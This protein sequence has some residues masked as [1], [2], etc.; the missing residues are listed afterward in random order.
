M[1]TVRRELW[2]PVQES[3]E[4]LAKMP[5]PS[6]QDANN[7]L[8][9]IGDTMPALGLAY[10][11]TGDR[12][13]IEAADRW[14]RALVAVPSWNGSANLGRSSWV[15]G[16]ALLYDWL[17][18]VLPKETRDQVRTRL[19][20]E[21]EILLQRAAYWRLLSNHCLIETSALGFIGLALAGEVP[22]SDAFLQKARERTGQIIEHAPLDGSWGE[23]IQY[24]QYGLGY[25]LRY[26]E[27]SRT[28]GDRDYYPSYEWL[29]KTGFFAIH[30]SLPGRPDWSVNFS[31]SGSQDYVGSFL[32]YLPASIYGNGYYQDFGNR[33]RSVAAYKFS[34]MDFLAYD[35]HVQPLDIRTLPTFKHFDDNGF[36]IMRSGWE[37]ASTLIGF[38]A[39]PAPGHRN[40]ADPHRLEWRGFGP[41]HGH[42]DINSFCLFAFGKWLALDPGYVHEKWT[43][44]HN[45]ILVNG[46]GQAGE[47]GEW[48]DYMA[49]ESR[50]P[51]PSILRAET[52]PDFDYVIGDAGGIY[53]DEARVEHFRRHLL[54]LKPHTVVI[55]DDVKSRQPSRVDWLLHAR[56]KLAE[57]GPGQYEITEDGV[58]LRIQPLLP[59]DY[60]SAIQS[61]ALRA[62]GTNGNIVSL[63][64]TADA[65]ERTTFLVVLHALGGAADKPPHVELKDARLSVASKE[66]VWN[67]EVLDPAG[68]ADP[69]LPL[70]R[71]E[72]GKG[73]V[74]SRP[75]S[76]EPTI[77]A[78]NGRLP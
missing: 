23:G 13:Y 24:W 9:F 71:V 22:R 74:T 7:R 54:F 57:A 46:R 42:P 15:V 17:Y 10:R 78:G 21:G 70:L 44:D 45:T 50:Q 36:V 37:P 18:E 20:A 3:A 34:W 76:S 4:R 60:R 25:L 14:L 12:R 53:V 63:D 72:P 51:A 27:A 61:R 69:S 67:I 58:R 47:G 11:M 26:L 68:V 59:K 64:L 55:L 52:N 1:S 5:I 73:Y 32:F 30:F 75:R 43:R 65:K 41:G 38:R 31:D 39:G 56:D 28:A 77:P 40:Q 29:K 6:M 33:A 8:R 16:G 66:R 62:S 2:P 49:F 19:T 48:L 35:P